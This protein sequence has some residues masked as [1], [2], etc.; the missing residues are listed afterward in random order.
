MMIRC[1]FC[2][3]V[4]MGIELAFSVIVIALCLLIFVRTK[5]MYA[6]TKHKGISYFRSTFLFFA[7]AFAFRFFFHLFAI[8]GMVF[9]F[10]VPRELF[11][12]IPL[13]ITTYFSTLAIL[14]LLMSLVWKRV[15]S[16]HFIVFSHV[17]AILLAVMVFAFH[18]AQFLAGIQLVLI[19][20][21][22]VL[23]FLRS[24]HSK[25]FSKLF[26]IYLLLFIGWLANIII[27]VPR[28]HIP[29]EL[30]IASYAVSAVVFGIIFYKVFRW[31]K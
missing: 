2:D 9:D 27:L 6:I 5:E 3:P 11:G 22:L 29:F 30:K 31:T 1:P 21:T 26:I 24:R 10:R 25:G 8:S 16:E 18:S 7:L 4:S 28:F 15:N 19:L 12:P 23:A 20:V 17:V 13:L 14:Y